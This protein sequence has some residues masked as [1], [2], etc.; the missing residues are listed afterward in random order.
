MVRYGAF[1]PGIP[2]VFVGQAITSPD[3][4]PVNAF[5]FPDRIEDSGL[6]V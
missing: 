5:A 2:T 6:I 4:I 1:N 3:L